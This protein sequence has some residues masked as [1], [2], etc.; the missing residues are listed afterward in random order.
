MKAFSRFAEEET[1][2]QSAKN[3]RCVATNCPATAGIESSGSLICR[4]HFGTDPHDWNAIT[5]KL[6][7]K[8]AELKV[9]EYCMSNPQ[10]SAWP[11]RARAC[12][13]EEMHPQ[14]RQIASGCVKNEAEYPTL[15]AQRLNAHIAKFAA[16]S[17]RAPTAVKRTGP[18]NAADAIKVDW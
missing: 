1:P 16:V 5:A 15:Y 6:R 18:V 9:A 3:W 17:K 14:T 4:F 13:P 7:E 12:L 2:V 8:T 10:N 11:D